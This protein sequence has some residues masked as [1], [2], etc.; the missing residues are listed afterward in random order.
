MYSVDFNNQLTKYLLDGKRKIPK[1]HLSAVCKI[2][3]KEQT[4]RYI[5]LSKIGHVCMKHSPM[6]NQLE[7]MAKEENMVARSDNCEGLGT[8]DD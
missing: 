6:K 3:Q 1:A 8:I 2:G 5:G 4:C 7:N